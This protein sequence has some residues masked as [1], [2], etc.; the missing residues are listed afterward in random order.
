MLDLIKSPIELKKLSL[1]ELDALA[2]EIREN[3]INKLS[4]C[5]GHVGSNLGFVE[6][7]IALHYVFN[8]P[9]DKFVFDTSHQSYVHKMLTGRAKAFTDPNFYRD[10]TGFSAP[11]ESEHDFF[12]IGH[13]STSVSL[14]MGLAKGRNLLGDKE[15][16]VAIIGD[17]SLS[18]GEAMEAISNAGEFDGN[19]IIVV[20]DNGMSISENHGGI[21]K[22]LEDL[23]RGKGE[24]AQNWFRAQNLDYIYVD[25]GN[26]IKSL[27]EAFKS[28]KD[29]KT[30]VVVH[31]NTQKGK[32]LAYAEKN[33]ETWHFNGP[34]NIEDGSPK[35]I[36]SKASENYHSITANFILEKA[37]S[38]PSIVA[39][40]SGTCSA[41]GLNLEKRQALGK[42]YLDSGI[43]E[44]HTVALA[45]GIAK[46]GGK[47]IYGTYSSF[48][49]RCYDQFSQDV[50]LNNSPVTFLVFLG[51]VYGMN[52]ITHLGF[53]DIPLIS[54]IPNMVY[55]AP[56]CKEEYLAMLSWSVEQTKYPVAIRVPG[57][58]LVSC[59]DKTFASDYSKLNKFSWD[60]KGKDVA[61]IGLGNFYF[62]ALEV[63][64]LLKNKGVN[65]SVINPRYITGI[66]CD[67]LEKLKAEHRLVLT[68]ED[69]VIDGGF[70]EKIARFYSASNTKVLV[71]G[72]AKQFEDLFEV[73]DLL[74]RNRLLDEQLVDDILCNL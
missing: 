41:L 44:E 33:L 19:L 59:P 53:F 74:C 3:L 68:L 62:K 67:M 39:L 15:N 24:A 6:A 73:E 42:Q 58:K 38:D 46:R 49:Q 51:S 16:I 60:I 40:A 61:I 45:S 50:C 8:S 5:G 64:E 26:D 28:V 30:P 57:G 11:Q 72:L 21:Y 17:G 22:N 13:T 56:T 25:A 29:R 66:D 36:A 65:A 63:A 9:V 47:P 55:L 27:V 14:A 48:F 2:V 4:V 23:R 71:R 32:G 37:K 10:V 7:T 34:F 1:L 70:G 35:K 12:T 52:S 43:A 18:G 20:N 54:N 69:G 31:I